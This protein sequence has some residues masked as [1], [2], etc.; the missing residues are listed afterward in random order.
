MSTEQLKALEQ[1]YLDGLESSEDQDHFRKLIKEMGHLTNA[2]QV[3]EFMML[4]VLDP[5]NPRPVISMA[6]RYTQKAID[7]GLREVVDA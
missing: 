2:K 7:R 4:Y 1:Y 6:L 5:S 3:I